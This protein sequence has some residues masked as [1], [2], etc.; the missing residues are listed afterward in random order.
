MN[1]KKTLVAYFS[2]GG[3]TSMVAKQLAR[4]A[5]ADLYE[6][7]P[8]VP[9]TEADLD[10]K[11]TNSRSSVEM[12]TLT[13]PEIDGK[14]ENFDDYGVVFIGFPV[15][16]YLAPTIING[17]LA[18]YDFSGKTVIPFATSGSSPLGP[19]AEAVLQSKTARDTKWLPGKLLNGDITVD[20]LKAWVEELNI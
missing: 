19:K 11:N 16:W 13:V 8:K 7:K 18:S 10:W 3:N 4:A 5:G 1:N 12:R 17:F 14:V 6:I 9:Y 2:V 15:W 20:A